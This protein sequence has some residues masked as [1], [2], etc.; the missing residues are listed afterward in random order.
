MVLGI[1]SI[2]FFWCWPIGGA[3]AI[4]GLPLGAIA[5]TRINNGQADPSPRGM[6]IAGLVL[7][8]VS[9]VVVVVFTVWIYSVRTRTYGF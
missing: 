4:V 2:V 6:A 5:F 3:C 9:L 1:V 7:S 8:I